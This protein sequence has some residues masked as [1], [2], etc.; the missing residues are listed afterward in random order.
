MEEIKANTVDAALEKH[1]PVVKSEGNKVYVTV[2][3][4]LHPMQDN[5]YIS[6]IFVETDKGNYEKKLMP[7]MEPKAVFEL[8]ENEKY[9]AAYAYCN[10]HGL[11]KSN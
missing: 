4:A 8:N 11:W 5:H 3:E 9:I 6:R 1:V 10:L 7:N 2:G